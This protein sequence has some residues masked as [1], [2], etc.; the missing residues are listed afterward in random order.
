MLGIQHINGKISNMDF[1]DCIEK[2]LDFTDFTKQKGMRKRFYDM[3][4]RIRSFACVYQIMKNRDIFF[5]TDNTVPKTSIIAAY[6]KYGL[7]D[8]KGVNIGIRKMDGKYVPYT[9]LI[10][11]S[12]HSTSTIDK[13]VPIKINKLEIYRNGKMIEK[14]VHS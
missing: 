1:F 12:S 3:K 7:V 6:I 9:V 4:H 13:L 10:D 5:V 8:G 14:I 11:R 2:G